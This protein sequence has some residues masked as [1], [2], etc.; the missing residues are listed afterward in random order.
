VELVI[1]AIVAGLSVASYALWKQ[2]RGREE[3]GARSLPANRAGLLPEPERTIH[4]LQ[5]GDV[6]SHLGTDYLVEGVLTLNDDGRVTRLYRMADGGRVKWLA[7]RPGDDRPL[8]LEEPGAI[9]VEANGP[10]SLLHRGLPY[11]LAARE[12]AHA[13][14]AGDVGRDRGAP[15]LNV[16]EYSGAGD[17]RVLALAWTDRVEAFAGE[18]IPAHLLEILPGQGLARDPG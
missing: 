4:N 12:T 2:A 13:A 14:A 10:E 17:A 1:L 16:F 8:L 18:R 5:P 15:R 6:V 9:A 3:N 11:R 7:A